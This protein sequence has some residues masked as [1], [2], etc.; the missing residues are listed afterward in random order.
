M[1]NNGKKSA[2]GSEFGIRGICLIVFLCF[3]QTANAEVAQLSARKHSGTYSRVKTVVEL[4][5]SLNVRKSTAESATEKD[6]GN[7]SDSNDNG[8]ESSEDNKEL[9]EVQIPLKVSAEMF[10]DEVGLEANNYSTLRHYWDAKADLEIN[11]TAKQTRELRE[12]RQLILLTSGL[13]AAKRITS[14]FGPLTRDEIELVDIPSCVFP[15]EQLLPNRSVETDETWAHDNDV[16]AGLLRIEKVTDGT[17]KSTVTKI[18]KEKVSISLSGDIKGSIEGVDTKIE[19]KGN[20]QFDR[21]AKMVTWIAL[22]I[23]ERRDV[24]FAAPGF[25][26][27]SRIR[28]ARQ[29]LDGSD[30]LTSDA[31]S[32][33]NLRLAKGDYLLDFISKDQNFQMATDRRWHLLTHRRFSSK[34]RMVEDGD[35][36]ATCRIDYLTKGVPGTQITLDGF[37]E[38]VQRALAENCKEIVSASQSVNSQNVRVLR[39]EASGEVAETPITWIYHHLSDDQGRRLSFVYTLESSMMNRFD[40]ADQAMTSSVFFLEAEPSNHPTEGTTQEVSQLNELQR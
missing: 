11:E 28:T 15:P 5:G 36:L 16:V 26:V 29:P 24:S 35:L 37:R 33:T 14:P 19:V 21:N 13:T 23:R 8:L 27:V 39:V 31:V 10:F 4:A 2:M 7:K 40:A 25:H 9:P 18:S 1:N 12:D 38:D 17:L 20:Y 30:M 6:K 32:R 22:A 34:L 3:T